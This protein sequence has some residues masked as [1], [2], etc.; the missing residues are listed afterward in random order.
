MVTLIVPVGSVATSVFSGMVF[1]LFPGTVDVTRTVTV[2]DPGVEATWAG[3]VPPINEMV[4]PI[5]DT[6]PP[7]VVVGL[8]GEAK[9]RFSGRVST[10]A[11]G[12]EERV[13]TNAFGL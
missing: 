8:A 10:Q 6:V 3:T 5:M 13:S 2:Q 12:E 7:Q 1:T 4:F 9:K 11:A